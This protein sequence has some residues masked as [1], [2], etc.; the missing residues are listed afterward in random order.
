[1]LDA[2]LRKVAKTV[3]R[4]FG[5]PVTFRTTAGTYNATT[6]VLTETDTDVT[7]KGRLDEYTDR[8]LQGTVK[9]GDR[10]LTVPALDLTTA[11]TPATKVLVSGL[12][13]DVVRVDPHLAT[14]QAA[15][16]VIQL[17]R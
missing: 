9:A 15:I 4:K 13:Y 17:R 12:V 16:Y 11:P 6:M 7:I 3:L 2:P 8:E 5:T 14:D 1:M 10:K